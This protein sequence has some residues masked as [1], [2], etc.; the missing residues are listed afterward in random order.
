MVVN[1]KAAFNMKQLFHDASRQYRYGLVSPAKKP[2]AAAQT[3]AQA[4]PSN[5]KTT[6][7]LVYVVGTKYIDYFTDG[8]KTYSF[9]GNPD[10]GRR[11][12]CAKRLASAISASDR[13][14]ARAY[15]RNHSRPK[16]SLGASKNWT[17]SP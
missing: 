4:Q 11:L 5:G 13:P 9:P 15:S 17:S 7:K 10:I 14:L 16:P 3:Q 1:V 12:C 2:Q 6:L 8:T